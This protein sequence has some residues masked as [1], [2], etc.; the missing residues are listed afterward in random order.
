MNSLPLDD[1]AVIG[2]WRHIVESA[3]TLH[4]PSTHGLCDRRSLCETKIYGLEFWT[5][6]PAHLEGKMVNNL[7]LLRSERGCE[8]LKRTENRKKT[9][10]PNLRQ[11]MG[12]DGQRQGMTDS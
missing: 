2:E 9:F 5:M 7:S 12:D 8:T 4:D 3:T 6:C 11:T 10:A 1:Y